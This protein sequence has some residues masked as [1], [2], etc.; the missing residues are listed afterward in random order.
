MELI[1]TELCEELNNYFW[2]AKKHGTFTITGHRIDLDGYLQE[3]QYFRI[4][5]S[6]LNDGVH[7]Y[8]AVD[9]IDEQFVGD[10]WAMAVPGTVVALAADIAAWNTKYGGVDGP[11]MS[12]FSSENF[13]NY[14]YSKASGTS[15]TGG[16]DTSSSWQGVFAARL[17]KYRRLRGLP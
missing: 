13:G 7:K 9:L 15:A 12:P 11:G 17:A 8:P 14:S 16:V 4:V 1:L 5:G 2:R 3:G 10:I 6:A